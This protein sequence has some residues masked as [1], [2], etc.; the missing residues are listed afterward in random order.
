MGILMSSWDPSPNNHRFWVFICFIKTVLSTYWSFVAVLPKICSD[1]NACCPVLGVKWDT[2][3]CVQLI[4]N[5]ASR[6]AGAAALFKTSSL[7]F[8]VSTNI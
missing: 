2:Y 3:Q 7:L 4:T 5:F 1:K 8:L 6:T